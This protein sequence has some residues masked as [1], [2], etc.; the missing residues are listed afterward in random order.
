MHLFRASQTSRWSMRTPGLNGD[1]HF[2]EP[3]WIAPRPDFLEEEATIVFSLLPPLPQVVQIWLNHASAGR[4]R[5]AERQTA[6][7]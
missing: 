1:I 7:L 3:C 5:S 4:M 6:R 2:R